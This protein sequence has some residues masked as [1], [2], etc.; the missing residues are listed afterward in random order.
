VSA[1][2]PLSLRFQRNRIG[3]PPKTTRFFLCP[4]SPNALSSSTQ[5]NWAEWGDFSSTARAD[6]S[7]PLAAKRVK[8]RDFEILKS[9]GARKMG[10]NFDIQILAA[11]RLATNRK[12]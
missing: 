11:Q 9:R 8:Y 3:E 12:K 6:Y 2:S 1:L 10:Q 5:A 7:E 4:L